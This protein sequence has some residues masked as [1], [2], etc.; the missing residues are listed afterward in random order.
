RLGRNW[1]LGDAERNDGAILLVAPNDRKVRIEVG[2]GLEGVLSDGLS[3]LIVNRT[4]L[5]RF[6]DGDLEG[7]VRA[8]VDALADQLALPADEAEA[9]L[10]AAEEARADTAEG[11]FPWGLVWLLLIIAFNI[12]SM[13]RRRG[14]RRRG[15]VILW[16][17]PGIGGGGRSY[18]GGF[19]GGFGGGGF[20]GGGGSFGGGGASGSW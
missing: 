12:W 10:R 19:G 4:I 3:F 18:G 11:G 17:M 5:P 1:G 8:G 9:R 15:G 6:R 16:G 13:S 20:S 7:G 2:Y 14:G